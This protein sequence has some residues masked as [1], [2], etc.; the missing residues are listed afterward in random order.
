MA[1]RR[2]GRLARLGALTGRVARSALRD[3]RRGDPDR[4]R[5]VGVSMSA[6]QAEEIAETLG[7]LKG[8]AMKAGQ[9]LAM[10]ARSVGMPSEV[11]DALDKLHAE[12]EPVPFSHIRD[13]IEADLEAPLASLFQWFSEHP[14]GTASLAQ[15]EP[16]PSPGR[17]PFAKFRVCC[18]PL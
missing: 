18:R 13:T 1:Q 15:A 12:A 3:R 10:V 9:Q 8:A 11:G 2:F 16:Q 17:A 7:K 6:E 4:S 14:I 5:G